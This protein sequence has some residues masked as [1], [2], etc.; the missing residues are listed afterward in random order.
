[1]HSG[2]TAHALLPC[3]EVHTVDNS[4]WP[5]PHHDQTLHPTPFLPAQDPNLRRHLLRLWLAPPDELPLPEAYADILGGSVEV[6]KRGGI[7]VSGTR[8]NIPLEAE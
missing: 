6:G 7:V 4:C 5:I 1:M 2:P 8:L 3:A